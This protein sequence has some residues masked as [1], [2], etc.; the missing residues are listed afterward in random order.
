M[1]NKPNA[2]Q[3]Q[4]QLRSIALIVQ[5]FVAWVRQDFGQSNLARK[6]LVDSHFLI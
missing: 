5:H 4:Q 6:T 3:Q 1:C 2:Q